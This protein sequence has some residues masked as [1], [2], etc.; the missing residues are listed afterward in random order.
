MN[1]RK[2]KGILRFVCEEGASLDKAGCAAAV[3]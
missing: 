1:A 3:S 2:K